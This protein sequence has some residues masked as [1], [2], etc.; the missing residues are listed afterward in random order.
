MNFWNNPNSFLSLIIILLS[1]F[2]ITHLFGLLYRNYDSKKQFVSAI[3]NKNDSISL[4]FNIWIIILGILICVIATDFY[5]I[6]NPIS[7]IL[8]VLA[9]WLIFSFGIGSCIISGISRYNEENKFKTISSSIHCIF[10]GSGITSFSFIPIIISI[11]CFRL[12][13]YMCGISNIII[14]GICLF[15]LV[16]INIYEFKLSKKPFFTFIGL[17]Q[18]LLII[19]SYASLLIFAIETINK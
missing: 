8:S 7:K 6:Y 10:A 17:W 4:L 18:R 5:I 15:L 2:I 13:L 9:F 14:S 11:L 12:S 1:Y 19:C 3:G 16:T